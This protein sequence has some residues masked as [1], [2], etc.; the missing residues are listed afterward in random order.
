M[1][2]AHPGWPAL[3]KNFQ[4]EAKIKIMNAAQQ[5][6]KMGPGGLPWVLVLYSTCAKN[7]LCANGRSV[8][9]GLSC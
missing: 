3:V 2:D 6:Q 7:K 1:I 5:T 8:I 9:R 4:I